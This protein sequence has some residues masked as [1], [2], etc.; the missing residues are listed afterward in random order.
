MNVGFLDLGKRY[1]GLTASERVVAALQLARAA[2][3]AGADRWWLA[4]H[5]VGDVALHAPE[6]ILALVAA[7]TERIRVGPAGVLLRYYSPLKVWETYVTLAAAFGNRVDLGVARGPGVADEAVAR[8]L[9]S[10]NET[11]LD[12]KSF[13]AKVRDLRALGR[14]GTG[15]RRLDTEGV[16]LPELWL[17]GSSPGSAV[18]ARELGTAYGFMCFTD[19]ALSVCAQSLSARGSQSS[20]AVLAV[21][22][23]VAATEG[24]ALDIDDRCE[25]EGLLRATVVGSTGNCRAQVVELVERFG[26]DGVVLACLS[27]RLEDQHRLVVLIA[28][29][30]EQP[31]RERRTALATNSVH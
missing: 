21:S 11:E 8:S 4:E 14:T 17:L 16:A 31:T 25:R 30:A 24:M 1:A 27:P 20:P 5:H 15:P 29:L 19:R 12:A 3:V 6:V 18:L 23:A 13:A 28:A 26:A 7:A 2:E 22:V 9:V 10:G